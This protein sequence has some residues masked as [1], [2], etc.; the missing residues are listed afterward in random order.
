MSYKPI[1]HQKCVEIPTLF[2]NCT[3]CP[4]RETGKDHCAKFTL[5]SVEEEKAFTPKYNFRKE[6]DNAI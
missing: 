4:Y 2:A 6:K 5:L 3:K 1:I